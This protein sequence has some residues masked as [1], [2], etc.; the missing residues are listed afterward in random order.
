MI[1][2]ELLEEAIRAGFRRAIKNRR[3]K[4]K[5]DKIL[6]KLGRKK[7]RT[8]TFPGFSNIAADALDGMM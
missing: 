4:W 3:N 2:K 7:R 1:R 8:R 5:R 6:K